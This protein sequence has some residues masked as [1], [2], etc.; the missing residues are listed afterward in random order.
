MSA[1]IFQVYFLFSITGVRTKNQYEQCTVTCPSYRVWKFLNRTMDV[2]FINESEF[3]EVAQ[4]TEIPKSHC[5][6][7]CKKLN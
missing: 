3:F 1:Q 6:G 7:K 4:V 2:Q 5:E